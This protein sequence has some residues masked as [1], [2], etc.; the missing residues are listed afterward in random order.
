MIDNTKCRETDIDNVIVIT[1]L[2][3]AE[4]DPDNAGTHIV[5]YVKAT[6]A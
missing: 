3:L 1:I 4:Y 5:I 2:P 6:T